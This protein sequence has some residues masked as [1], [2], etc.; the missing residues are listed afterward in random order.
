VFVGVSTPGEVL[1]LQ[2]VWNAALWPFAVLA[3]RM[4]RWEVLLMLGY[5]TRVSGLYQRFF[6]GN[7]TGHISRIGRGQ[8]DHMIVQALPYA[9]QLATE[10]FLPFTG[11][12]NLLCGVAYS[13][14]RLASSPSGRG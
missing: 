5:V 12:Q 3:F 2:I 9:V 13:H 10:G 1:P 8:V 6:A 4:S 11:R 14:G 7:S